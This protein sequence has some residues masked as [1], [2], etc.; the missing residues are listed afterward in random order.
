MQK[1][2]IIRFSLIFLVLFMF[3]I[4]IVS[5]ANNISLKCTSDYGDFFSSTTDKD[6]ID[7]E[8]FNQNNLMVLNYQILNGFSQIKDS[9]LKVRLEGLEDFNS[10]L[11]DSCIK[12]YYEGDYADS[13]Q[14][15]INYKN[16]LNYC[17]TN[18]FKS[19]SNLFPDSFK[20]I[21]YGEIDGE[22]I[23]AVQK[24]I[25]IASSTNMDERELVLEP[26]DTNSTSAVSTYS[27]LETKYN[28]DSDTYD[29]TYDLVVGAWED[30]KYI[31]FDYYIFDK[32]SPKNDLKSISSNSF[33][34][35]SENP[36]DGFSIGIENNIDEVEIDGSKKLVF[37]YQ[38]NNNKDAV[39]KTKYVYYL[40]F[41]DV[42]GKA[43]TAKL[44]INFLQYKRISYM[45]GISN[46]EIYSSAIVKE[47]ETKIKASDN[48]SLNLIFNTPTYQVEGFDI[49]DKDF[50]KMDSSHFDCSST[51]TKLTC[52]LNS[53]ETGRYTLLLY[54]SSS[55]SPS[56]AYS[57]YFE[58]E[59]IKSQTIM[60]QNGIKTI[61]DSNDM[62]I[63]MKSPGEWLIFDNI[64]TIGNR[65]IIS[66]PT[67]YADTYSEN[68]Y[69]DDKFSGALHVNT[70]ET[71][72]VYLYITKIGTD[73]E[74]FCLNISLL[75]ED[76]I[77]ISLS[78]QESSVNIPTKEEEQSS[79]ILNREFR[80]NNVI[81]EEDYDYEIYY[82]GELVSENDLYI[83][84]GSSYD[85]LM[86]NYSCLE[87][88]YT[89]KLYLTKYKD[90]SKSIDVYLK[91]NGS[92]N[93][94]GDSYI[95]KITNETEIAVP[96]KE[97]YKNVKNLK[98]QII[99]DGKEINESGLF[100]LVS[101]E[102]EGVSISNNILTVLNTATIGK[103]FTIKFSYKDN[104]ITKEFLL[105]KETNGNN[106][107]IK[108]ED[109]KPS[110]TEIKSI[111]LKG[112]DS[113]K[114][115]SKYLTFSDTSGTN[116]VISYTCY[117]KDGRAIENPNITISGSDIANGILVIPNYTNQTITIYANGLYNDRNFYLKFN[118]NN[119]TILNQLVTAC[120]PAEWDCS[121]EFDKYYFIRNSSF[122]AT[123]TFSNFFD[124]DINVSFVLILYDKNNRIVKYDIDSS[125][126]KTGEMKS[127]KTKFLLPADTTDIT[128]KAFFINGLN[129]T[130]S[131]KIYTYSR[132][133]TNKEVQ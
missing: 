7:G 101:S 12:L 91:Y 58:K 46:P 98:G 125:T 1:D 9:T 4:F 34:Y 121:I 114:L 77:N 25:Q 93:P 95:L 110:D 11:I 117:D 63:T 84:K 68:T 56:N 132:T 10:E 100:E 16:Y 75:N 96:S 47:R 112:F 24:T 49:L 14:L 99:K 41:M 73:S 102:S 116:K 51:P 103:K 3:G 122:S 40:T 80:K 131:S 72:I 26:F 29:F 23:I 123:G 67:Y 61:L 2:K 89:I 126:L 104:S 27:Y 48:G 115:E 39:D 107:D 133:I 108:D 59:Q 66:K 65:E 90:V 37:K 118:S 76:N 64:M 36:L 50:N 109:D 94:S 30:E 17:N 54:S 113:D 85:T 97:G 124:E 6:T 57:F 83:D 87:G 128:V 106:Q 21:V 28:E 33:S 42:N 52:D 88:I 120:K 86:V 127:F 22:E 53:L 92:E 43:I 129:I 78:A 105:V 79:L 81:I 111:V 19:G 20:I 38:R 74:N 71:L 18:D 130:D 13:F 32:S 62:D 31:A 82:K 8:Y 15:A 69:F 44:N 35:F 70:D 45:P 119:E 5:A 55:D 60:Y